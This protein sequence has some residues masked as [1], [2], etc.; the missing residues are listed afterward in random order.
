MQRTMLS[1]ATR[2][3]SPAR[4]HIQFIARVVKLVDTADLKS[5]A[6]V[7]SG[8][9]GSIPVS[10]TNRAMSA[11]GSNMSQRTQR[12]H[13]V[14]QANIRVASSLGSGLQ[15]SSGTQTR[16]FAHPTSGGHLE[17]KRGSATDAKIFSSY[18]RSE[19]L[20]ADAHARS[21]WQTNFTFSQTRSAGI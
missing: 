6:F 8:R 1:R 19:K 5:A 4:I 13:A 15:S 20:S 18:S 3:P 9:T 17:A 2:R 10:G 7:N 16:F 11:I 12:P 14:S 21:T